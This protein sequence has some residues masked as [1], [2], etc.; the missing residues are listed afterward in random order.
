MRKLP[1]EKLLKALEVCD[2]GQLDAVLK[3]LENV[4][5][6]ADD[7][8]FHAATT[9]TTSWQLSAKQYEMLDWP[10]ISKLFDKV[11]ETDSLCLI[12][13]EGGFKHLIPF[14]QKIFPKGTSP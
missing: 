9:S 10:Y 5:R 14:R 11:V 13:P 6:T 4:D 1:K 8:S 2:N 3:K 12:F 7:I